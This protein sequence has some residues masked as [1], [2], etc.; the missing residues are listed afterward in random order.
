MLLSPCFFSLVDYYCS[1]CD[2]HFKFKSKLN[3]H[4]YSED[5]MMFESCMH[6]VDSSNTEENSL[7]DSLHDISEVFF[8]FNYV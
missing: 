1:L 8:F 3:R 4:L 2:L 6:S 7:E 5:H